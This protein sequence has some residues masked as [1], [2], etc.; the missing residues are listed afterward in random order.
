MSIGIGDFMFVC[1]IVRSDSA[2]VLETGKEYLV[3]SRLLPL[4]RSAGH[5]SVEALIAALRRYP[6]G[7]LRAEVVE[8]MTTNETS[9]FRDVH[10]FTALQQVI[11]PE[12]LTSRARER[13]IDVWCA[14]ASSG[15]EPYSIAMILQDLQA[16]HPG[17]QSSILATDL[18]P[19]MLQRTREGIYSQLEVNRGLPVQRLLAHFDRTGP[20]WQAKADLRAMIR[21]QVLNLDGAWPT[22]PCMDIVMLRNVLI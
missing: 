6:Y 15:Q 20:H 12:L 18:S 10:P 9:F 22:V 19:K 21:T 5:D 8:A 13:R 17:W 16:Q 14:A 3:E 2:I 4:A 1:D 7:P 11:L